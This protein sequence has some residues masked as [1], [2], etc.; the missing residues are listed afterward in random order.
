M[1]KKQIWIKWLILLVV[2]ISCVGIYFC[3][4]I[5]QTDN[6]ETNIPT[7]KADKEVVDIYE[8]NNNQTTDSVQALKDSIQEGDSFQQNGDIITIKRKSG[9]VEKYEIVHGIAGDSLMK[10]Y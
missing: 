5:Y 4:N 8:K 9:Y 3:Q 1:C 6:E 7:P 10:I 2:F